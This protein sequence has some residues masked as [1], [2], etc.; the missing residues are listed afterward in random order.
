MRGLSR[1]FGS[2][3][4]FFAIVGENTPSREWGQAMEIVGGYLIIGPVGLGAIS[5]RTASCA[6]DAKRPIHLKDDFR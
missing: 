4:I 3:V 6:R 5:Y 2:V 1:H